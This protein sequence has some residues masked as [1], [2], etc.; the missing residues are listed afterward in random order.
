LLPGFIGQYG[1]S[2]FVVKSAGLRLAFSLPCGSDEPLARAVSL[3]SALAPHAATASPA[4]MTPRVLVID[5]VVL[6]L[7]PSR[8]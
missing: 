7:R 5:L 4:T 2:M 6:I 3:L 1:L 8:S